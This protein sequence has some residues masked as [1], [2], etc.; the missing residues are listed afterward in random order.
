LALLAGFAAGIGLTI[1]TDA[2]MHAMGVFPPSGRPTPDPQLALATFYRTVYSIL[3]A[4]VI[5]RLAPRRPMA[6]ALYGG[7]VGVIMS[8][9]GAVA[10]WNLGLGSHWYP[11]ALI[12]LAMPTSWAGAKLYLVREER[13]ERPTYKQSGV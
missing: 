12:A 5:A 2:L 4:Y 6:H 1:G 11:L 10:T 7:A 3:G 9:L 8:T 13:R